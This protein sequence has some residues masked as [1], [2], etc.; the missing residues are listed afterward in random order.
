MKKMGRENGMKMERRMRGEI[1]MRMRKRKAR[2]RKGAGMERW[3]CGCKAR[4]EI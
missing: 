3:E 2:R 4:V 1:K